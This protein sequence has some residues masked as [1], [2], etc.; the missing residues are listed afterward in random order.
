MAH[1]FS[2]QHEVAQFAMEITEH[3]KTQLCGSLIIYSFNKSTYPLL[4]SWACLIFIVW[5]SLIMLYKLFFIVPMGQKSMVA[6]FT[7]HQRNLY[8]DDSCFG[9]MMSM[10]PDEVHIW[11]D[12]THA[13]LIFIFWHTFCSVRGQEFHVWEWSEDTTW[14]WHGI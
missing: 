6:D 5:F 9:M 11:L 10:Y 4:S 2:K 7:N 1:F 12:Y 8:F 3:S 13:F 14:Y